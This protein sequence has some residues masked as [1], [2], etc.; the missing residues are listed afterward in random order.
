MIENQKNKILCCPRNKG[1]YHILI[2]QRKMWPCW[3]LAATP[4]DWPE[5]GETTW[6]NV[7][8]DHLKRP[9]YR[10]ICKVLPQ[11]LSVY[12]NQVG[13]NKA[14]VTVWFMV[15]IDRMMGQT[16][17]DT[18]NSYCNSWMLAG[19]LGWCG[20]Y[21]TPKYTKTIN[22]RSV[23]GLKQICLSDMS[24]QPVNLQP[25]FKFLVEFVQKCCRSS[26]LVALCLSNAKALG[27]APG[28]RSWGVWRPA[29]HCAGKDQYRGFH[30]YGYPK[31]MVYKG[32]SY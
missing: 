8:N 5:H 14:H 11:F 25:W 20:N 1:M 13:W 2:V 17:L 22:Y 31:W 29:A 28:W 26:G 21:H 19:D 23:F 7:E 12:K 24:G 6:K 18:H 27:A 10:L 16:W 15:D 4:A 9:T 3:S 30:K 32:K